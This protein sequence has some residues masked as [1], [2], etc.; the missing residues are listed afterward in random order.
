[1]LTGWL[2]SDCSPSPSSPLLAFTLVLFDKRQ[3]LLIA[4]T[5]V[6]AVKAFALAPRL[7]RGNLPQTPYFPELLF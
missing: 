1:V 2:H 7:K 5:G 3:Q 6:H 4:L